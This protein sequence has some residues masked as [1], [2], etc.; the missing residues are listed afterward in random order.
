MNIENYQSYYLYH[1]WTD[2]M[3]ATKLAALVPEIDEE[4][5]VVAGPSQG[6]GSALVMAALLNEQIKLC[7]AAIPS[8]CYWDKRIDVRSASGG[9]ISNF[10]Y[11]YPNKAEIVYNTM[12]YYDVINFVDRIKCQVVV[13]CGLKDEAVPA[14]C[15]YAA[16]NKINAPKQINVYAAGGHTMEPD[17]TENWLRW[18]RKSV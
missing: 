3:L 12:T 16:F 1:A 11:R 18:A 15:I 8:Y 7:L 13:S 6:G 17:E 10:I 14:E 5:M 4:R 9:K 2:C